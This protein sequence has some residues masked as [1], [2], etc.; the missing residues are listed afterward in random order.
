VLLLPVASVVPRISNLVSVE[1]GCVI[2]ENSTVTSEE[3][4][5]IVND[6]V[7]SVT[8]PAPEFGS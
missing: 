8:T 4:V 5:G 1:L 2:V 6:S 7:A 3:L